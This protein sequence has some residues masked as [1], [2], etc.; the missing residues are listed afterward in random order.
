MTK[1]SA[2]QGL[3]SQ[4]QLAKQMSDVISLRERVA[5][6]ELAAHLYAITAARKGEVPEVAK[7]KSK[8]RPNITGR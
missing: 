8:L 6:A 3:V 1:S 5:Q 2:D 4:D 7:L